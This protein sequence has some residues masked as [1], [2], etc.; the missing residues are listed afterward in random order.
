MA[1]VSLNE[2]SL[3]VLFDDSIVNVIA[4]VMYRKYESSIILSCGWGYSILMLV[5]D[6]FNVK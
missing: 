6:F 5:A 1:Y 3:F 4:W 2:L